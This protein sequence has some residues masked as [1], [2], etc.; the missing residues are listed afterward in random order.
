M[1]DRFVL[2]HSHRQDTHT[3]FPSPYYSNIVYAA[4]L[5]RSA[6]CVYIITITKH[7]SELSHDV[8]HDYFSFPIHLFISSRINKKSH[9][10]PLLIFYVLIKPSISVKYLNFLSRHSYTSGILAISE[11]PGLL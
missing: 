3:P 6:F 8:N 9:T 10:L 2:F 5:V 1:L 4:I 7:Y 11:P